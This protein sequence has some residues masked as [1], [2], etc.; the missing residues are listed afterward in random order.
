M[1]D[2][3]PSGSCR[4]EQVDNLP[5]AQSGYR[6]CAPVA[7]HLGSEPALLR[8]VDRFLNKA[9]IIVSHPVVSHQPEDETLL[10]VDGGKVF[11]C[12]DSPAGKPMCS[13]PMC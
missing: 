3:L 9:G 13:M 12:A 1:N 8:Q 2:E 6:G 5:G 4:N 10:P 11:W 7:G